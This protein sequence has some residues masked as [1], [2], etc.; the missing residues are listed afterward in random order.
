MGRYK[1]TE[2]DSE[3]AGESFMHTE[4]MKLASNPSDGIGPEDYM[5]SRNS[6]TIIAGDESIY[7]GKIESHG[8]KRKHAKTRDDSA[9]PLIN[10]GSCPSCS[11]GVKSKSTVS[12]NDPA[13]CPLYEYEH[14]DSEYL[15]PYRHRLR[16]KIIKSKRIVGCESCK[17]VWVPEGIEQ[18]AADIYPRRF[19]YI[20]FSGRDRSVEKH[21]S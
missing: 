17:T 21:D 11:I 14:V 8:I 2:S 7:F 13:N 16:N 5:L 12:S 1:L 15:I 3:L 18:K 20:V 6:E 19:D 9:L 10:D 4:W